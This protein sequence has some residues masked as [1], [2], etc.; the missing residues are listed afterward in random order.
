MCMSFGKSLSTMYCSG[1]SAEAP[2]VSGCWLKLKSTRSCGST[3]P[4]WLGEM[5]GNG[6]RDHIL[7]QGVA[8]MENGIVHRARMHFH[9]HRGGRPELPGHPLVPGCHELDGDQATFVDSGLDRGIR[10]AIGH[11]C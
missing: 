1:N 4:P 11:S 7:R 3:A 10:L 9:H 6:L 2:A 8:G 5:L